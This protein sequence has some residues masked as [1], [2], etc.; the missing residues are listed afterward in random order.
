MTSTANVDA[1]YKCGIPFKVDPLPEGSSPVADRSHLCHYVLGSRGV[2]LP[3]AFAALVA[4]RF[5]LWA[6]DWQGIEREDMETLLDGPDVTADD[7]SSD[8]YE[9]AWGRV[10][11]HAFRT[12][13]CLRCRR[14]HIW[15]LWLDAETDELLEYLAGV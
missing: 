12:Q 7:A 5:R 2:Y 11:D 10:L 6:T 1:C 8:A 3:Q 4:T 14:V 9:A 13:Q 15:R